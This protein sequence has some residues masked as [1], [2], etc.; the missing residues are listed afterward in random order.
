VAT[1]AGVASQVN[2]TL[3]STEEKERGQA[4]NNVAISNVG[5]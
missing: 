5:A 4:A 2:H 1:N 3:Y